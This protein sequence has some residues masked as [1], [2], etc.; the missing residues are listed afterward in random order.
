MRSRLVAAVALLLLV[1]PVLADS[2]GGHMFPSLRGAMSARKTALEIAGEKAD[3]KKA[4]VLGKLIARI[5][6][7]RE[8]LRDDVK[9]AIRLEKKIRKKLPDETAIR[10]SLDWVVWALEGLVEE[11]CVDDEFWADS[12]PDSDALDT[13]RGR[14]AKARAAHLL[15]VA[16]ETTKHRLKHLEKA[17]AKLK[18]AEK[19]LAKL[20]PRP[21][22]VAAILNADFEDGEGA[23]PESW[24]TWDTE[25]NA[26]WEPAGSGRGGG[27]C[28][29]LGSAEPAHH[30]SW[31]QVV[32]HLVPG[33]C[34]NVT[35]WVRGENVVVHETDPGRKWGGCIGILW[36]AAWRSDRGTAYQGTFDWK[37]ITFTFRAEEE[38]ETI[39]LRLGASG[40]RVSGKVWFDDVTIS[41]T[42][43]DPDIPE[44]EHV[45]LL[46]E[47]EDLVAAEADFATLATWVYRLDQVCKA[48]VDL[49]GDAPYGGEKIDILSVRQYPGGWAIAGN[50]ILWQ[51]R[52]VPGILVAFREK[53]DWSFG[54]LHELAHDHDL[55]YRW[56]YQAEVQANFK[57]VYALEGLGGAV[58]QGG[59]LYRGSQIKDCYEAVYDEAKAA[60]EATNW[61]G[62]LYRLICVK[63]EI[64]WEPFK[65][66]YRSYPSGFKSRLERFLTFFDELERHARRDI[67]NELIPADEWAWVVD[68]LD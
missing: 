10:G 45:R 24:H 60:G 18:K 20:G 3:L 51:R 16:A 12:L 27:R 5:D 19:K 32:E 34:Y 42:D 49:V 53:D 56:V 11:T 38:I 37:E 63:D 39:E 17:C 54:I 41:G 30:H 26:A 6:E 31:T 50:P 13:A 29:S 7:P 65:Q 59:V 2:P 47:T 1:A 9:L 58:S 28:V 64:G 62:W 40:H 61:A 22:R 68:Q 35:A 52:Y 15:A 23:L 57:M 21:E 46:L 44:G 4:A 66:T 8:T 14:L 36:K 25:G 55:D 33:R 67:R 43:F 48:Y